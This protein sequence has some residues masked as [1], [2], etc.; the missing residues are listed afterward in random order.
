MSIPWIE[1]REVKLGDKVEKYENIIRSIK[2][3]NPE[4]KV[5][6][7]T[8]IVD[9]LGGF[10]KS[11]IDNLRKLSFDATECKHIVLGIQKIVMS[12]ARSLINCF[13]MSTCT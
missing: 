1:N 3:E 9:C 11:L 12:E 5:D 4:F 6:Q 2:C 10:S 7:V 8:F 13:K